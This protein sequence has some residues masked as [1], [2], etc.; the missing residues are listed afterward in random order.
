[1]EN[2]KDLLETEET[3]ETVEEVNEEATEEVVEETAEEAVEEAVEEIAEDVQ[4]VPAKGLSKVA[5]SI[6]SIAATLA[7][8]AATCAGLYFI[9]DMRV[10]NKYNANIDGYGE[11]LDLYARYS[12]KTLDEVKEEMGLPADMP[13]ETLYA[14]A[15]AY[16]PVS[17]MVE[18]YGVTVD[19]FKKMYGLEDDAEITGETPIGLVS[20][21]TIE[22]QI[23]ENEEAKKTEETPADEEAPA[24]EVPADEEAPAE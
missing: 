19:D 14:I 4:P 11:T 16:T 15:N 3:V 12:E 22:K 8:T 21:K 20:K 18:M 17:K 7:V 9:G 10:C 6:I 2:E 13:G 23:A 24:E 1:M 5:V